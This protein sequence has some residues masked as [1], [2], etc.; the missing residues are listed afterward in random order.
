MCLSTRI[1]DLHNKTLGGRI[2]MALPGGKQLDEKSRKFNLGVEDKL[3][4]GAPDAPQA[5]SPLVIG[6]PD[7]SF[8]NSSFSQSRKSATGQT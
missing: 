4:F 8:R 5:P 1:Q 2:Q 6:G 7:Q 3:G